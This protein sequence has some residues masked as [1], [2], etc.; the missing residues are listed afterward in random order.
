MRVPVACVL[1]ATFALVQSAAPDLVVA[2]ARV[3][4]GSA[5]QPWAEAVSVKGDPIA[6]GGTTAE[7]A[8]TAGSA[9]KTIDAGG[10]LLIPGINDAHTHI[11]VRPPGTVVEGAP[12]LETDSTRADD[13]T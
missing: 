5:S 7:I 13:D 8:K 4:T 1:L 9:T 11:G 2:N 3:F 12:E 10:R 6:A